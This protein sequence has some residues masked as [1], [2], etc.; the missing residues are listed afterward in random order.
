MTKERGAQTL[1]DMKAWILES[2]V[3]LESTTTPRHESTRHVFRGPE[4]D[5]LYLTIDHVPA[6]QTSPQPA[7]LPPSTSVSSSLSTKLANNR[8]RRF[9]S[10]SPESME[11]CPTILWS[12]YIAGTRALVIN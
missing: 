10:L 12:G 3:L 6:P 2:S 11:G 9:T 7:R 1:C 8:V 4:G 5:L